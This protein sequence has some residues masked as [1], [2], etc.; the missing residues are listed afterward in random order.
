[1]GKPG[2]PPGPGGVITQL[3]IAT[4]AVILVIGI[5][6]LGILSLASAF[7]K[8]LDSRLLNFELAIGAGALVA[9]VVVAFGALV[10]A[11][12]LAVENWDL[13]RR[14]AE[15]TAELLVA[16]E[17]L[18]ATVSELEE[19]TRLK[20]DLLANVSHE[21]RTPLTL[22][23]VA[24]AT[25][26]RTERD[27]PLA[28]RAQM[29]AR[30]DAGIERLIRMVE[31]LLAYSR[32]E[33]GRLKLNLEESDLGAL[34]E[35]TVAALVPLATPRGVRVECKVHGD[36]P[37]I[38][39]DRARVTQIVINLVENAI[40][41]TPAGG[42]I[43]VSVR[44]SAGGHLVLEVDDTG[45]GIA[46]D[47][48]PKVF[49]R[50]YQV[51]RTMRRHHGGTGLGLAVV[52]SLAELHGGSVSVQSHVGQGTVFWVRLPLRETPADPGE[53]ALAG[54]GQGEGNQG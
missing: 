27:L 16:N 12:T 6:V 25:L 18:S 26:S 21:L 48:L 1:M 15:K 24:A 32:L 23:K 9:Q 41:F 40:K 29:H 43:R 45:E 19:A 37:L 13:D 31:D 35:Q 52:R 53:A 7:G 2:G 22:I 46:P 30:I 14:V 49:E 3:R 20:E 10:L 11:R 38:Q 28:K 42:R 4:L 5:F 33:A 51:D 8:P 36:L 39:V 34:V 50:F 44:E 54:T 17:K 47:H